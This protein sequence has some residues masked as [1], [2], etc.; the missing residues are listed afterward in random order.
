MGSVCVGN[1]EDLRELGSYTIR[2]TMITVSY[3]IFQNYLASQLQLQLQ[4]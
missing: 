1:M 3:L 2:D 4:L